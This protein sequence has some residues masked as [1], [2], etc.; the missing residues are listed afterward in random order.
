MLKKLRFTKKVKKEIKDLMKKFP[1]IE[2]AGYIFGK[3][4]KTGFTITDLLVP[5]QKQ[6]TAYVQLEPVLYKIKIKNKLLGL[7]HSHHVMGAFFSSIDKKHFLDFDVSVIVSFKNIIAKKRKSFDEKDIVEDLHI[8]GEKGFVEN[9][10]TVI[11]DN[12]KKTMFQEQDELK[13]FF[14]FE[15]P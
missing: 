6:F 14:I 8:V 1:D 13:D 2:W 11:Q 10:K 5:D 7:I 15:L 4:T 9:L 12:I 3:E